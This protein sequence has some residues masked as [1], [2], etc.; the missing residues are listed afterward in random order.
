MKAVSVTLSGIQKSFAH[1]QVL[2][3]IHLE[4]PAGQFLSIVGPS[5]SGKTTLLRIIAGFIPPDQGKVSIDGRDVT[6]LPSRLRHIGMV[7][8]H[9]ALFPNLNVCENVAFGLRAQN[10]GAQEVDR[11]I[12]DVLAL[13]HLEEKM[14]R[15]PQ[16]LSGGEKRRVALA[17]ALAIEPRLLLL[18]EL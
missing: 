18:D 11:R 3:D 8:Q 7:F 14:H 15:I 2:G 10:M 1:T 13:V 6:H 17:R 9:Y 16:E 12:K 4:L 5:G